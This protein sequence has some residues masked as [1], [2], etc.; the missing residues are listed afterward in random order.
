MGCLPRGTLFYNKDLCVCKTK[1]SFFQIYSLNIAIHIF[2]VDSRWII[3]QFKVL[4]WS[5][6]GNDRDKLLW[7]FGSILP[8][9]TAD[10]IFHPADHHYPWLHVKIAIL[11]NTPVWIHTF[12]LRWPTTQDG[13]WR[14]FQG[15]PIWTECHAIWYGQ[16]APPSWCFVHLQHP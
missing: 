11:K 13:H 6:K 5:S 1:L 10:E 12:M 16:A 8:K 4:H 7:Q 3:Q 9:C 15:S 2:C 14:Y